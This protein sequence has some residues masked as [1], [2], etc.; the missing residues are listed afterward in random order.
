MELVAI[1]L[2][3]DILI[4]KPISE[5]EGG[6]WEAIDLVSAGEGEKNAIRSTY[7][8]VY[9][10]G[11]SLE[12][13]VPSSSANE[14]MFRVRVQEVCEALRARQIGFAD[15]IRIEKA[16]SLNNNQQNVE[17]SDFSDSDS[18]DGLNPKLVNSATEGLLTYYTMPAYLFFNRMC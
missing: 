8:L 18:D 13:L 11:L 12:P 5:E 15:P 7:N 3:V 9:F 17:Y 4:S 10:N 2:G 14:D 6:G 16:A 1:D